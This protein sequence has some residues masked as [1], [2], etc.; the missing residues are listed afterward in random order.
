M[1]KEQLEVLNITQEVLRHLT[2]SLGALNPQATP[3]AAYA[4]RAA[5]ASQTVSPMASKML[6]DLAVGLEMVAPGGQTQ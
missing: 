1:T 6:D 3:Q 5:A 2:L 4:L